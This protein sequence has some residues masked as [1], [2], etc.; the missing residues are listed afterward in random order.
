MEVL[1]RFIFFSIFK[2]PTH[3]RN[4]FEF[5]IIG[6]LYVVKS[7]QQ[8]TEK[9]FRLVEIVQ[10]HQILTK[11]YNLPYEFRAVLLSFYCEVSRFELFEYIFW[12]D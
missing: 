12:I 10:S 1:H 11:N 5:L 8:M 7:I 2:N 3:F 6:R 9:E 4:F